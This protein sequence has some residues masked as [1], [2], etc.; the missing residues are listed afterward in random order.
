MELQEALKKLFSL[1]Q[2]GI[3]LG[4]DNIQRLL[5]YLGNPEKQLKA[6]HIAGSNGKGSTASF[7]ASILMESGFKTGL[8]TSPHLVKFN[9]RIRINGEM[10]P[11]NY[12]LNFIND[13]NEYIDENSPTFFE[14]TTALAFKYFAEQNVDYAVIETGLGGRLDAT[15][16]LEPL[17][18]VVTSISSEHTN[19]LGE[20]LTQIAE[21]KGGIIK[22]NT[23]LI[24]G[25]MSHDP[26]SVLIQMA[27]EKNSPY[28]LLEDFIEQQDRLIQFRYKNIE[29]DIAQLPLRGSYQLKNAALAILSLLIINPKLKKSD[30]L[31]GL[32]NVIMNSGIQARYEIF[33]NEPKI[34]FDAAHNLE[35][36]D[37]F[38]NE[39]NQD[40]IICEEKIVIYGTM[41]DKNIS[42]ILKELNRNFDKIFVT[43][44]DYERAAS[45]QEIAD[46]ASSEEIVITPMINPVQHIKQFIDKAEPKC[47]VILGSIYILGEIKKGLLN[48]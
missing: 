28:N 7:I 36:I 35:G 33:N 24:L 27:S 1:H 3:K 30:I 21:E 48:N 14:L 41:K 13:M 23:P 5:A 34:I 18:S 47:L 25:L 32:K 11:D 39:F 2:F 31:M 38:L 19:I 20:E 12:I 46:I 42:S 15:N 37:E 43:E 40:N 16:V 9:E 8:Y 10:I 22:R 29:I 4:L 45:I 6:I 44:I 17:A 26:K